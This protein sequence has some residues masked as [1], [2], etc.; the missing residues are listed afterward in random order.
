MSN[1]DYLDLDA[2]VPTTTKTV[3]IK[4]KEYA[5]KEPTVEDFAKEMSR[6]KEVDK[7]VAGFKKLSKEDRETKE[8]ELMF[9]IMLD[10]IQSAFPDMPKDVLQSLTMPQVKAI[11]EFIQGEVNENAED[12]SGNA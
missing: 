9:N 10:G 3:K 7:T 6:I 11:R 5:F 2:A 4:G 12:D 8:S 1:T